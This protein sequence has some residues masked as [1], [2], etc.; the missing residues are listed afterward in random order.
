MANRRTTTLF[1][2]ALCALAAAAC[3]NPASSRRVSED[4]LTFVRAADN[5]PPLDSLVVHVWAKAG[6]GRQRQIRYV[7]VGGYEG[8]ICLE[9]KIPTDG[10]WKRP[11]GSV[12]QPG[13]SVL[14]TITVLDP[15]LFNFRFEPA[16]LQ[17]RSDHPA[18]LRVSYKWANR[19][20]NGD[21]VV[22]GADANFGFGFWKQE[23]DGGDWTQIGTVKDSNVEELR[24]NIR[25]FTRY[26][27]AGA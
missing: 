24:A 10:L 23:V 1:A 6:E 16:G 2:A 13:D 18:E 5:A 20:F 9:F 26:A 11:D 19:D 8:D 3:D 12:V 4:R 17:F 27:I 21:G 25:G 14:I 7:K 15:R 22:N